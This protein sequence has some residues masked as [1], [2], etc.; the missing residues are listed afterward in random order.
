MW[1][2]AFP[3]R[4]HFH[5]DPVWGGQILIRHTNHM[6]DHVVALNDDFTH[7]KQIIDITETN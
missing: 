4:F 5:I 3:T 2:E 7:L 1:S 6:A